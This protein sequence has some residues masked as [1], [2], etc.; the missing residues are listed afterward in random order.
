M[1]RQST[2]ERQFAGKRHSTVHDAADD[3]AGKG[4][5]ERLTLK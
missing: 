3:D 5:E 1:K 2:G 4:R